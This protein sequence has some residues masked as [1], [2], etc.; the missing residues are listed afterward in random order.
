MKKLVL[1]IALSFTGLQIAHSQ[2]YTPDRPGIGN[3]YFITPDG[4]FGVE[5]G[6]NYLTTDFLDQ[7]NIGQVLLRY[8]VAEN[9]ELRA[10]LGSYTSQE[11]SAGGFSQTSTGLQDMSIGAKY[12]FLSDEGKPNISG[13]A[14]ISLPVG[15][16]AFSSDEVVPGLTILADHAIDETFSISSNLGYSFG[17]GNLDDSWL[18]T[19]TPGISINDNVGAYVGY[20]GMYYGDGFNDN[21]IE[22]GLTY[23]LESGA[24]LDVNFGYETEAEV[25]FIGAGF[26]QG[27]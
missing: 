6:F 13:L 17:V 7:V 2:S 19:L 3:G 27:F 21:W 14:S 18:F 8:G 26:A 22:G 1:I 10:G 23:G 20:A 16:D 4:V 24:Q 9:L 25:F 12:N 15:D 11:F 5:A